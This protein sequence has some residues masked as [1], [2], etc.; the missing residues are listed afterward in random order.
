[1]SQKK[2][3]SFER[4]YSPGLAPAFSIISKLKEYVTKVGV[5]KISSKEGSTTEN[6]IK[7]VRCNYITIRN[8]KGGKGKCLPFLGHP[9]SWSSRYAGSLSSSSYQLF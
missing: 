3:K 6:T 9:C 8:Q 5:A 1:M 2:E 4:N 7:R